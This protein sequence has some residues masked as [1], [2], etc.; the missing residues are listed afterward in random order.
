MFIVFSI[1][2]KRYPIQVFDCYNTV[3]IPYILLVLVYYP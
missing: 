2:H 3:I 1:D